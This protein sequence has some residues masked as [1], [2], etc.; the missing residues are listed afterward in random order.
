VQC[1]SEAVAGRAPLVF[2]EDL[3]QIRRMAPLMQRVLIVDPTVASARLLTEVMRNIVQV[4]VWHAPTTHKGMEAARQVNP[5]LV[6]AELAGLTWMGWS[7]RVNCAA[8]TWPAARRRSS[9]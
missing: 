1:P 6:F 9:W 5:Q 8:R 7:S 4:Q 3:K 2:N